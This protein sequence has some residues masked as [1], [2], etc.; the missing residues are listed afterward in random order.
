MTRPRLLFLFCVAFASCTTIPQQAPQLSEELGTKINSL[1]KSHLTL[2]HAYFDQK[3]AEVDR[4]IDDVWV[5]EFASNF[6]SNAEIQEAWDHIVQSKDTK[7]R[8]DFLLAATP[9]LQAK[10]TQKRQELIK[11][12]DDLE[13]QV[14]AAV[15]EEFE[16]A[17]SANNTITS[18]LATTA[19]IDE[20][21]QRYMKMLNISEDKISSVIS[22]TDE[23][24]AK[25]VAKTEGIP[26]K[27]EDLKKYETQADEYREKLKDLKDKLS[28]K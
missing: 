4:F 3:R 8:L 11:P 12:L 7:E 10:I 5:P 25:L 17:R 1:E 26:G 6:F 14:E 19:K 24:L 22:E 16:L 20:N 27:M 23:V 2:L 15:R 18:F 21:R 9:P 13:H 28:K